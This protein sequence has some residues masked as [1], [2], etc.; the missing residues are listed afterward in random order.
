MEATI[1]GDP[2]GETRLRALRA[3]VAGGR[4]TE[5]EL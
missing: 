5:E 1:E 2:C 4:A 3:A